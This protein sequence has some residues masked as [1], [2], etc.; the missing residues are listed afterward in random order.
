MEIAVKFDT[1]PIV[2]QMC[3]PLQIAGQPLKTDDKI[4]FKT[5]D[6]KY[7]VIIKSMYVESVEKL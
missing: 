4:I 6:E 1:L 3:L 5:V 7:E 2:G